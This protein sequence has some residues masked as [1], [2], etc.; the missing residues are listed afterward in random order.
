MEVASAPS[1]PFLKPT[2]VDKPLAISRWVCDSVVRAPIAVQVMSS[3]RY[4]GMMG[5]SA[6][7]PAGEPE[8]RDVQE[9]FAREQYPF[10]DVKRVVEI[11]IVDEPLPAHGRARLLEIHPHDQEQRRRDAV[12]ERLQPAGILACRGHIVNRAR[13]DHHEQARIAPLENGAH[14]LAA[15]QHRF[16]GARASA[17]SGVSLPRGSPTNR[18]R[19]R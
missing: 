9:Q 18:S 1:V 7:V 8:L 6:S 3:D 17:A 19:R 4:C 11:R 10:L 2:G 13:T 12:G 14:R 5:S 15:V 16:G